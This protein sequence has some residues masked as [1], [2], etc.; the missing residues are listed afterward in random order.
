MTIIYSNTLFVIHNDHRKHLTHEQP[1]TGPPVGGCRIWRKGKLLKRK[2]ERRYLTLHIYLIYLSIYVEFS[3]KLVHHMDMEVSIKNKIDGLL[4]YIAKLGWWIVGV[5]ADVPLPE[6]RG[7]NS[8]WG[9]QLYD[10]PLFE[11]GCP[12]LSPGVGKDSPQSSVLF[13][14]PGPSTSWILQCSFCSRALHS[15]TGC[16]LLAPL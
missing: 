7:T 6:G 8:L 16:S 4:F 5:G 1:I 2:V 12:I 10:K 15:D 11:P 3:K 13:S 14:P 9:L